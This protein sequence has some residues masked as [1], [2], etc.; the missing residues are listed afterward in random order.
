MGSTG[1]TT[2]KVLVVDDDPQV[3]LL[4]TKL[5]GSN[6]FAVAIADDGVD[7]LEKLERERF[8][9]IL[10]DVWMPR[11]NGLDLLARVRS[12]PSAPPVVVMTA[13]DTPDTILRAFKDHACR[14]ISKPFDPQLL[15]D[16]VLE[17]L[18]A[19][20]TTPA[21]EIISARPNWV[22]VLVPCQL[23]AAESVDGF[24]SR[25][26]SDL[27]EDVRESLGK[28]F[29]ELL[30]NA[31]EWGGRLDPNRKVRIAYL[32]ARRLVLYRISDPGSGFRFENLSHA[33][34]SDPAGDPTRHLHVREKKG[35]RPGGFGLLLA[36]VMVDELIYNEAQNEVVIIKYLD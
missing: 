21:I 23:E 11:M 19:S 16:S 36:K 34:V 26:D 4:L 5:L 13:Y 31:I 10:T 30:L 18:A 8:D 27:P 7:G 25:L 17:A 20:P 6:G 15:L 1:E 3:C 9:L 24:L 29:R 22:E 28:V 35:L 14:Y 32:R 2:K 33:A 12:R